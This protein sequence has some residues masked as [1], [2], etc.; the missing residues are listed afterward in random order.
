VV[1][2]GLNSVRFMVPVRSGSRV[3]LHTRILSAANKGPGRVM[4]KV[5]K[6]L[7]IEG[8]AKPAMLAEQLLLFV[9]S[10]AT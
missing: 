5:E 1:N 8:Q 2:Y 6:S 10:T 3:R 4:L 7:E 9:S